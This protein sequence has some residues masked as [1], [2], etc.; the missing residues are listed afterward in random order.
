M[1]LRTVRWRGTSRSPPAGPI[2]FNENGL[3]F[4]ADVLRGQKT[5]FFFDQRENRVRVGK[6]AVGRR[7][8]N[9]LAV[10][11][12]VSRSTPRAAA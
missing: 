10:H 8:L 6:A 12:A 7:T 11:V 2:P 1:P 3:R 4:E 9:V 5:G